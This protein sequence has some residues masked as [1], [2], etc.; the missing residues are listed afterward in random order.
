MKKAV[1]LKSSWHWRPPRRKM[2]APER[3]FTIRHEATGYRVI[4]GNGIVLAA[5]FSTNAAA[6]LHWINA[7]RAVRDADHRR[8]DAGAGHIKKPAPMVEAG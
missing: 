6:A 3:Q 1:R 7:D 8:H 5:G 4:N 2:L